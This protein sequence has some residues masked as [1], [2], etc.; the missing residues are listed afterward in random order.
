MYNYTPSCEYAGGC[1]FIQRLV[2]GREPNE[3]SIYITFRYFYIEIGVMSTILASPE[4]MAQHRVA[5]DC[6]VS[7]LP[8][9]RANGNF[10]LENS[11]TYSHFIFPENVAF[12][13]AAA[14]YRSAE[15]CAAPNPQRQDHWELL[16]RKSRTVY[17]RSIS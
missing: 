7:D 6:Q 5:R 13:C 3:F 14:T 8:K 12:A 9:N 15:D 17:Q 16:S 4:F 2:L 10:F 11:G 1:I